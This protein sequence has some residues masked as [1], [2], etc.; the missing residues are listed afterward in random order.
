MTGEGALAKQVYA[1]VWRAHHER[2]E[3]LVPWYLIRGSWTFTKDDARRWDAAARLL[4][5]RGHLNRV[6]T[7]GPSLQALGYVPTDPTRS[8]LS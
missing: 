7:A 3:F 6:H 5:E 1:A 2:G 8:S 4:V